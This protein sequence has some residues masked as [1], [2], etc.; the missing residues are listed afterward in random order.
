MENSLPVGQAQQNELLPQL[1]AFLV[2]PQQ[3]GQQQTCSSNGAV[4]LAEAPP[5]VDWTSLILPSAPSGLQ[6]GA[7]TQQAMAEADHVAAGAGEEE[8]GPCCVGSSTATVTVPVAV[9]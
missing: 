1:S 8:S 4:P 3:Q 9:V 5:L 2:A 6:A 7:S